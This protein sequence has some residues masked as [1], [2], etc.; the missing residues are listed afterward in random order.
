MMMVWY[1]VWYYVDLRCICFLI[2]RV[3][4]RSLGQTLEDLWDKILVPGLDEEEVAALTQTGTVNHLY[5]C[6][7]V[8]DLHHHRD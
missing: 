8:A 6:V 3:G 7:L 4:H 2:A 1:G 5:S